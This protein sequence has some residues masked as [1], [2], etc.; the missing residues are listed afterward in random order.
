MFAR[1]AVLVFVLAPDVLVPA[2]LFVFML[3]RTP[4]AYHL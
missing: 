1:L 3:A 4:P 2:R